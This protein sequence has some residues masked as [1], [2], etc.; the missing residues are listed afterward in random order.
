MARTKEALEKVALDCKEAGAEDTL[1]LAKDVG[2][3]E[4][5]EEVVKR[6]VE[7]FGGKVKHFKICD[8]NQ[9][10]GLF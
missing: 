6:T 10:L 3:E 4:Q 2:V 1:V 9:M 5:C 7:H 8:E